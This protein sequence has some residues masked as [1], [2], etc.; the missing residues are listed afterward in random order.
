MRPLFPLLILLLVCRNA[1]AQ[2][3]SG[4]YG[5]LSVDA[6]TFFAGVPGHDI[7]TNFPYTVTSTASGTRHVETF[8]GALKGKFTSP[9]YLAGLKL[10]YFW[11]RNNIDFG[12]G[13]YWCDGG[14]HGYYLKGGYG[15]SLFVGGLILRPALDVYYLMGKNKMGT[16]DNSGVKISLMDFT[17]YDQFT[18]EDDDGNDV[19]YNADHL[20]VNYRRFSLLANPK[21]ILSTRPLGRLVF[22][23]EL[24]CLLQLYQRC[25]L[26]LE[27]T[28]RSTSATYT[29]G[30]VRLDRNGSLGGAFAAIN[31]GVRL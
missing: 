17:A 10:G 9:A 30:K 12:G 29:V 22:G 11:K 1:G 3:H 31:I 27:Q 6:A 4:D 18:A 20:D 24:G 21:I 15:Y 26:Q 13:F 16:I 19:T 5:I 14:D 28:S 8:A 7:A 25:D 23:L 2:S